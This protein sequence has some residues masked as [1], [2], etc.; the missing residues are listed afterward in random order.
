MEDTEDARTLISSYNAPQERIYADYANYM[1]HLANEARKE[2]LKT[3]IPKQNKEAKVK[4]AKEIESLNNKLNIAAKNKPLERKAQFLATARVNAIIKDN[5]EIKSD[6]A[7]KKKINQQAIERARAEVGADSKGS[8]VNV[9]DKEWEAIQKGAISA[10]KLNQ[11]IYKMDSDELRKLA[12]PK[13]NSTALSPAKVS[14]IKAMIAN[15][16]TNEEI[17]NRFGISVSTVLKYAK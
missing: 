14:G 15:G 2:Y 7:Y 3:E 17:A 12:T 10:T 6:K 11:I 9:T 8:K 4:Y 16:Y 1:K 5:P 13:G